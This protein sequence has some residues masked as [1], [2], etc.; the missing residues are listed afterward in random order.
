MEAYTPSGLTINES[1][2][3]AKESLRKYRQRENAALEAARSKK[4]SNA[5][6]VEKQ[7][8]VKIVEKQKFSKLLRR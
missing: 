1:L 8:F 5:I 2:E 6:S 4:S 7:K 3:R